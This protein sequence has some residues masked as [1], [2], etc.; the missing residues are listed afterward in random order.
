VQTQAI[1]LS[2]GLSAK[3]VKVGRSF[4]QRYSTTVIRN[5]GDSGSILTLARRLAPCVLVI[6]EELTDGFS[7]D[8][9]S[10]VLDFGESIKLL[11]EMK[12]NDLA[13][14]EQLIRIGCSGVLADSATAGNASRALKAV[15]EGELWASRA[16]ISDL[17]R[18]LL[19]E[20]KHHLTVRESEIL[21]LVTEGLKNNEIGERLF[22]SP[23]TVRWHLRA[24]YS[25]IG[26]HDRAKVASGLSPVR[27]AVGSALFLTGLALQYFWLFN[28]GELA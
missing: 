1:I 23:Q 2:S 24:L 26:I 20:A 16:L 27:R 10:Q 28:P 8:D 19:R 11:V 12:N 14:E 21:A 18:K 22:I 7:P 25:K 13:R 3:W 5:S 4:A 17:V 9:L 6:E 15:A